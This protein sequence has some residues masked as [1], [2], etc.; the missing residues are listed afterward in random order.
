[1]IVQYGFTP[2]GL[3]GERLDVT[4][5]YSL[6]M[7]CASSACAGL[8]FLVIARDPYRYGQFVNLG[9]TALVFAALVAFIVGAGLPLEKLGYLIDAGLL[10]VLGTLLFVL[11]PRRTKRGRRRSSKR[12]RPRRSSSSR[13]SRSR[14]SDSTRDEVGSDD[15]PE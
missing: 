1:L 12:N 14:R 3:P 7:A 9:A 10:G 8:Y 5:V 11:S 13:R 2:D 6:R 15:A 4:V